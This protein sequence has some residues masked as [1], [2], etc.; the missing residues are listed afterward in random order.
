MRHT[1][2]LTWIAIFIALFI[3]SAKI[4][5]IKLRTGKR[6]KTIVADWQLVNSCLRIAAALVIVILVVSIF[7]N[8]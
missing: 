4:C 8:N 1:S 7:L 2:Q 6:W 3:W 5:V